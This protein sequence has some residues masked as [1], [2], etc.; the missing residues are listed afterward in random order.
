MMKSVKRVRNRWYHFSEPKVYDT[1]NEQRCRAIVLEIYTAKPKGIRED[2]LWCPKNSFDELR[3]TSERDYETDY[4]SFYG[5]VYPSVCLSASSPDSTVVENF[6]FDDVVKDGDY[7]YGC[8]SDGVFNPKFF[9][10]HDGLYVEEILE[11]YRN[12]VA[13]M[14]LNGKCMA[15]IKN[16]FQPWCVD[17]LSYLKVDGGDVLYS[18]E[19]SEWGTGCNTRKVVVSRAEDLINDEAINRIFIESAETKITE[20]GE[21]LLD[22]VCGDFTDG[23]EAQK[24]ENGKKYH[25]KAMLSP[26]PEVNPNLSDLWMFQ[27]PSGDCIID[28][29]YLNAII[30]I[31]LGFEH[32][33]ASI[34]FHHTID[35]EYIAVESC[36]GSWPSA[37]SNTVGAP[38][39]IKKVTVEYNDSVEIPSD[40][41]DTALLSNALSFSIDSQ[42]NAV[43]QVMQNIVDNKITTYKKAG[44][45]YM[46]DNVVEEVEI[47][48]EEGTL[49]P[50]GGRI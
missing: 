45:K 16:S 36:S 14:V 2:R 27:N 33:Y 19:C 38:R 48:A 37:N 6:F 11:D 28:A 4:V 17:A 43:N 34:Q 30:N 18:F 10:P 7:L 20:Y 25:V 31:I 8:M 1:Q 39:A 42:G 50:I 46:I 22:G 15:A 47:N 3:E 26:C 49:T 21:S 24:C 35:E 41:D 23:N 13:E 9:G 40:G 12:S 5:T 44:D 32:K 29:D